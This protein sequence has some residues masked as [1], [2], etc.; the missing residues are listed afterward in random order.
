MRKRIAIL[1]GAGM[2]VESGLSTFRG[3]NGMWD[4]YP[5]EQVATIEGYIANPSLVLEF[6]NKR[7]RELLTKEPNRGHRLIAEL[8]KNYDVTVI[9][10]NV[11]DMHERAG[12]TNII[13]LHGEL[14]K[15][16]SSRAP[17]DLSQVCDIPAD[18]PEI[19]IGDKA[20][21]GSQLRPFIVWFG[22][23][24]PR[25]EDAILALRDIDVFIIIGTSLNVYP[26]AGLLNYVSVG[27]PIYLVDP[28]DVEVRGVR[29]V[30]VIKKGASDGIQEIIDKYL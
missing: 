5:V 17:H 6:Y 11:D 18:N 28:N 13:H 27:V 30:T 26:A 22:E 16:C 25:I 23:A 7:R 24:V 14:M 10:Q 1:T 3:G 21:D 4:E 9:T 2:S 20:A 8:E 15:A 12:S 19:K 29:G